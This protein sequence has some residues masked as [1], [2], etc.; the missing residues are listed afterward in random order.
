M[1]KLCLAVFLVSLLAVP[2]AFPRQGAGTAPAPSRFV[3][4]RVQHLTTLLDLT[5]DQV[6]AATT[7]FTNAANS[8]AGP[9]SQLHAAHRT[10]RAD[11]EGGTGN[12][13]ADSNAIA[14]LEAQIRTNDASAEKGFFGTLNSDQQTKYKAMGDRQGFGPGPGGPGGFR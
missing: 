12:I 2:A 8:N 11:I 5:P 6:S 14:N 4:R 9:I 3:A 1:K 7:A 10:L 13:Q